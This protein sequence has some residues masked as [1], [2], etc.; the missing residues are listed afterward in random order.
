MCVVCTDA[1]KIRVE[2]S[3]AQDW[4]DQA[5]ASLL[6]SKHQFRITLYRIGEVPSIRSLI[7]AGVLVIAPR[8]FVQIHQ[9]SAPRDRLRCL[10]ELR[11][12]TWTKA[13]SMFPT[14]RTFIWAVKYEKC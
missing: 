8:C 2:E 4:T 5:I 3:W 9:L 10:L 14:S 1:V 6:L 11:T 13:T 7:A 12:Y